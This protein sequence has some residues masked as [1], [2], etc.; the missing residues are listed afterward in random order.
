MMVPGAE[1]VRGFSN[2]PTTMQTVYKVV[3]IQTFAV[4]GQAKTLLCSGYSIKAL[5]NAL[6]IT[7]KP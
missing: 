2:A 4:P 1:T 3:T 6:R 5:H 7:C